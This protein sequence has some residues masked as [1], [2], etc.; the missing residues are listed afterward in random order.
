[1]N[2]VCTKCGI[3]KDLEEYYKRS[4]IEGGRQSKCKSCHNAANKKYQAEHKQQRRKYIK[5]YQKRYRAKY[6]QQIAKHVQERAK[7]HRKAWILI[8]KEIY[9]EIACVKCGYSK[10]FA[11][12]DFHHRKAETKIFGISSILRYRVT[13]KRIKEVKKCDILCSNCHRELHAS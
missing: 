10:C 11:A 12:L 9:G 3:N 4:A 1:M 5:E 13:A 2:K 8:L 6:R 7:K